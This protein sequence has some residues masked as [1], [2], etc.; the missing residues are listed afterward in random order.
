MGVF[1]QVVDKVLISDETCNH[2]NISWLFFLIIFVKH[3]LQTPLCKSKQKLKTIV[4]VA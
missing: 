1:L 3:P 2:N 4:Q